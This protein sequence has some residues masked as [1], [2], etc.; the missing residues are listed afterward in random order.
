[1]TD[2]HF[3]SVLICVKTQLIEKYGYPQEKHHV[4]TEDGYILEMH[5]IAKNDGRPVFLMHG[6]LDSSATWVLNGPKS[7]LGVLHTLSINFHL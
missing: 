4:I 7:A 6:L 1:M 2:S 3:F 5:R